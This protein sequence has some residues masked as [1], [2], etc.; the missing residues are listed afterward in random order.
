MTKSENEVNIK[1][2]QIQKNYFDQKLLLLKLL[3]AM[4]KNC[5]E[6][7]DSL[8]ENL[9]TIAEPKVAS[10]LDFEQFRTEK[11]NQE[12]LDDLISRYERLPVSA[13]PDL[14]DS[15]RE[16]TL[17]I[18]NE[19]ERLGFLKME[20]NTMAREHNA[21]IKRFPRNYYS[22]FYHFHSKPYYGSDN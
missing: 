8:L 15:F 19:Q 10:G 6:M 22:S 18:K 21:Y 4:E 16:I 7:K 17:Q 3:E 11:K 20:Y 14:P 5:A 9:P 13:C 1:Y 12:K 2:F